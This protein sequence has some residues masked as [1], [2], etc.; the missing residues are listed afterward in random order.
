MFQACRIFLLGLLLGLLAGSSI[1]AQAPNQSSGG[2]G[3][4]LQI[5]EHNISPERLKILYKIPYGGMVEI[6][7]FNQKDK[8]VWRDQ[9]INKEGEHRIQLQSGRLPA[10]QYQYTLTYKGKKTKNT[11]TVQGKGKETEAPEPIPAYSSD[12]EE[13]SSSSD[14][15][16]DQ[17]EGEASSSD[18]FGDFSDEPSEDPFGDDGF[19]DEPSE[20]P[21]EDDG[22]GDDDFGFD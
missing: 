19:E 10:G 2:T 1:H 14:G 15:V 7:L 22:F 20:D 4:L 18:G 12:A 3:S 9:Y 16:F 8:M 17:K 13:S 6:R 21:F 11:F 5:K